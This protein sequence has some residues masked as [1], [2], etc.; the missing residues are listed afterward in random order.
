MMSVQSWNI[1]CKKKGRTVWRDGKRRKWYKVKMSVFPTVSWGF[2]AI[3]LVLIRPP[4]FLLPVVSVSSVTVSPPALPSE[5]NVDAYVHCPVAW[6][7]VKC[8]DNQQI[9]YTFIS[10]QS[11]TKLEVNKDIWDR[12][13]RTCYPPCPFQCLISSPLWLFPPQR[14]FSD[15]WA[16]YICSAHCTNSNFS[17]M[18]QCSLRWRGNAGAMQPKIQNSEE[19]IKDTRATEKRRK[20]T[21]DTKDE[22]GCRKKKPKSSARWKA[23]SSRT[24]QTKDVILLNG[25]L[26]IWS[27]AYPQ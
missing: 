14:Q 5:R 16:P 6:G 7:N 8:S 12:R 17:Q 10:C 1:N 24:T 20:E 15:T 27:V 4:V 3:F 23:T 18:I 9:M 19:G 25:Q 26:R 22:K 13:W 2:P 21:Y 11:F